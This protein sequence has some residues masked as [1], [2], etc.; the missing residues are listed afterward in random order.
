[1]K[2]RTAEFRDLAFATLVVFPL[3]IRAYW[4]TAQLIPSA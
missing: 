3:G 4:M 1:M 2:G